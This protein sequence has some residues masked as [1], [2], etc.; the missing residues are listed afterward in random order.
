MLA[1]ITEGELVVTGGM[2]AKIERD[3]L[4]GDAQCLNVP[5]AE[6]F[7]YSDCERQTSHI[8]IHATRC[9]H[10]IILR[11]I[12]QQCANSVSR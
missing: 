11:I 2:A 8:T 12:G 7:E 10:Q 3:E 5:F 6:E 1:L 9:I 4:H